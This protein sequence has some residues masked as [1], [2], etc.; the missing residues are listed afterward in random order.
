[1]VLRHSRRFG[2]LARGFGRSPLSTTPFTR[3]DDLRAVLDYAGIRHAVIG[4]HS[5]GG[6]TVLALALSDPERVTSLVLLAPGIWNYP[7]PPDDPYGAEFGKLFAARDAD[8]LVR[9]GLAT[10]APAGHGDEARSQITS[11]V[12]TFL[13]DNDLEL[14]PPPTYRRLGEIRA[15]TVVVRGDREYPMVAECSDAI[16][17]RIPGSRRILIPGADHMLPLRVPGRLA[18]I[19]ADQAG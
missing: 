11:A 16:A 13:A 7:W 18:E 12:S 5:G 10:W 3:T 15:P 17:E 4:G 14:P 19:I 1:V 9:L 2:S 6:G 8:G